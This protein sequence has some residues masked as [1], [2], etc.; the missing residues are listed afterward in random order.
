MIVGFNAFQFLVLLLSMPF[1]IAWMHDASFPFASAA[2][3]VA[4][5]TFVVMSVTTWL[6]LAESFEPDKNKSWYRGW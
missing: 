1:I 5:V 2:F 3:W 4:V 6:S